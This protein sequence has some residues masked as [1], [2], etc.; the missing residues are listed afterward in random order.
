MNSSEKHKFTKTKESINYHKSTIKPQF[1]Y[2]SKSQR[3]TKIW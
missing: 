2:H 1:A 3:K